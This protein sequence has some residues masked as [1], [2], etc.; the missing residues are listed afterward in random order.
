[1]MAEIA[2]RMATKTVQK[3]AQMATNTAQMATKKAQ[4]ATNTV[5]KMAQMAGKAFVALIA[6]NGGRVTGKMAEMQRI[7]VL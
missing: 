1:M 4:M 6:V 2:A 7:C 3:M 5:E